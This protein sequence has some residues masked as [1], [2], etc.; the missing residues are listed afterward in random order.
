MANVEH[1]AVVDLYVRNLE[2]RN[3]IDDDAARVVLLTTRLCIEAR[4]IEEDT[5][6]GILRNLLG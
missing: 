5:K 3:A 1:V 6:A 2:L 4:A